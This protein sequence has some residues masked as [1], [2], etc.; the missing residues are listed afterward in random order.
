MKIRTLVIAASL[1]L[2]A[3]ACNR[4]KTSKAVDKSAE[5]VKSNAQDLREQTKDVA[6]EAKDV[7][8]EANDLRTAEDDFKYNRMVRIQTLR[9]VHAV[10]STEP[11]VINAFA[12]SVPLQPG[13]KA[14]IAEQL[15]IFQ[16][17]LDDAANQIQALAT[18]DAGTWDQR[19]D[20]VK[21]AMDRLD[22]ARKDAWK[23]LDGAKRLDQTSMR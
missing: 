16:M 19:S 18:V 17:R 5:R 3:A 13:D 20:D 10:A 22:D 2:P 9:G 15:Q 14:A 12:S 8:K 6:D 4:D 23:A 7:G 11:P 1:L 21:K